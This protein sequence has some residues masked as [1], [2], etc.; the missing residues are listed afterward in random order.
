MNNEESTGDSQQANSS[1]D[2]PNV[3]E[4]REYLLKQLALYHNSRYLDILEKYDS[5]NH[6]LLSAL[7]QL[8]KELFDLSQLI[9]VSPELALMAFTVEP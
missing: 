6:Q 4:L 8:Y 3:D 7:Y 9:K 1:E 5:S 2:I